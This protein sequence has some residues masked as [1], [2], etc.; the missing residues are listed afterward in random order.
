MV[1]PTKT[2]AP[3]DINHMQRPTFA[4]WS[5][6]KQQ[7]L[8]EVLGH[9]LD[10][11]SK[12][13]Q[14]QANRLQD[15]M[16]YSALGGGKRIRALLCYATAELCGTSPKIADASAAAV[17]LIHAYSLVH[18][19]MPCMDDD[20]LRRGKPSCHKQYDDATAL[21]TGDALQSMAF[22][23]LSN[24]GLTDDAALQLR[25]VNI[26]AR[27]SGIAGM[28]GG[29]AIDLASV[30]KP[31]TQIQLEAM[32]HLKTGALIQT[33]VTLGAAEGDQKKI[34]AVTSYAKNIGLA[35]QVVDDI[36]DVEA[37]SATLG[38]TAGKDEMSNKPTYVTIL[39]LDAAKSHANELYENALIA[40]KPYGDDAL[41]LREIADLIMQRSF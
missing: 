31:L 26:L 3:T 15:A 19:D 30:G 18:D 40:I 33:A 22:Y 25:L 29:Q 20:D 9:T 37:D 8:E 21:L 34:H 32:H 13:P 39:G 28:A 4:L 35:F 24:A 41:R 17:E 14:N 36:L 7:H 23:L 27:A 16:R 10:K 11:R 1:M 6:L 12:H 5:K 38:K 2:Q